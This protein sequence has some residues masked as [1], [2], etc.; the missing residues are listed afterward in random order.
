[1]IK[2]NEF[3]AIGQSA[4]IHKIIQEEDTAGTFPNKANDLLATPR[5]ILWAINAAITTI[6]PFL[7]EGYAS[8][9]ISV[10]LHHKA[11]TRIGMKVSVHASITAISGNEVIFTLKAWDEQGD[12][13]YGTHKRMVFL[14]KDILSKIKPLERNTCEK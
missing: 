2:L 6:E 5:I 11:P 3:L 7:P 4:D 14:K 1:M 12:I 10:S 8:I 9:G 13:A